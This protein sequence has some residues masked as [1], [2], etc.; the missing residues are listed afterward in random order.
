MRFGLAVPAYGSHADPARIRDLLVAADE[1]GFDGAWFP[2][3]IAVPDYAAA[4]NLSPPFLEPLAA[5]AWG[6][7]ITRRLRFGTDVLVAPYRHALVVA[8]TTNTMAR[9]APGRLVLGVGVGYLKGEFEVLGAGPY[10]DRGAL[11]DGFLEALRTPPAGFTVVSAP[12]PVPV[13]V[14]GNGPAAQRRAALLGDGWHP[15]WMPDSAY[16]RARSRIL[17]LRAEAGRSA[18]FTFSYSC[19]ATRVLERPAT[20]RPSPPAALPPA[21]SEFSYAPEPWLAH[22][23]RPRFV[24]TAEQVISDLRLLEAVGVDHVTLRFGSTEVGQLERFAT[25]VGPAFAL[26]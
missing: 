16:A 15:L 18:P 14:G 9:L 25:Q 19:G 23:G 13:W 12:D 11:T 4:V 22:D 26:S 5:C 7:G 8:A 24:G 20:S 2:D 21:G 10:E 6:L 3:H 17:G 1:L